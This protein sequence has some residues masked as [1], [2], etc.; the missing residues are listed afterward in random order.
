MLHQQTANSCT[1]NALLPDGCPTP[2]LSGLAG[3]PAHLLAGCERSSNCRGNPTPSQSAHSSDSLTLQA[4][5]A[6][7]QQTIDRCHTRVT[8][9]KAHVDNLFQNVMGNRFRDVAEEIRAL[10]IEGIGTWIEQM[11]SEFLQD[12]YL[13]YVAWALSD[14]VRQAAVAESACPL[15]SQQLSAKGQ[16]FGQAAHHQHAV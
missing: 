10:V 5:E 16:G 9:L 2:S 11:P 15:T 3:L 7:H 6:T 14:K 1:S 13:K 8:A 4:R 12:N